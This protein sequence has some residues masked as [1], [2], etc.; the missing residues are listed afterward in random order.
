M[1]KRAKTEGPAFNPVA[2]TLVRSV[3]SPQPWIVTGA[4]AGTMRRCFCWG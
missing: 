2:D 4:M 1:A 3:T